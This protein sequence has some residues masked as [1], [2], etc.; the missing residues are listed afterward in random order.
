ME[1]SDVELNKM[2]WLLESG[3]RVVR[4]K[5]VSKDEAIGSVDVRL[6]NGAIQSVFPD[7]LGPL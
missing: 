1:L 2:Y 7:E 4:V 5:A 6:P 3:M